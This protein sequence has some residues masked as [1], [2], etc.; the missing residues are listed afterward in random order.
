MKKL[1]DNIIRFYAGYTVSTTL[2]TPSVKLPDPV[3][4]T[5][6]SAM[7]KI[8]AAGKYISRP[9]LLKY[10]KQGRLHKHVINARNTQWEED[11]I[12]RL[13]NEL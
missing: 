4:I 1:L 13:I 8:K 2:P 3:L 9:T 10:A 11:E 12:D 7:S 5:T 6:K